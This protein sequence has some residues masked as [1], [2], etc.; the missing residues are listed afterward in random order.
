MEK[1]CGW[2]SV[3]VSSAGNSLVQA[4]T[5]TLWTVDGHHDVFS[6]QGFLLPAFTKQFVG[7]NHPEILKHRKRN[8]ENT[9]CSTLQSLH[10]HLFDCLQF[11]YWERESWK[12]LKPDIEKLAQ[13]IL[14][15]TKYLQKSNKR[16]LL[17]HTSTS[18]VWQTA[19]NTTFQFLP[20]CLAAGSSVA[21][22][23]LHDRLAASDMYEYTAVESEVYC[24]SD[25]HAKYNFTKAMKSQ[26]FLFHTA[27]L[28]YTHGNNIGNL[29][30]VW[31]VNPND[32]SSSS[33]CQLVIERVKESIPTYHTRAMRGCSKVLAV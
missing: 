19:E 6:K 1:Q 2:R 23:D 15:Y 4:L 24:L 30:F 10:V 28:T 9:S 12:A 18:P 8:R 20:K 17:N 31:K 32:E 27:L 26:G 29:N 16:M 14:N 13:S 21:L 22:S 5:D 11:P 33:D 25:S 3:E 7:Y